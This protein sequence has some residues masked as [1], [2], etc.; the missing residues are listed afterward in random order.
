MEH[1]ESNS[2]LSDV[3]YEFRSGRSCE[4]QLLRVVNYWIDCTDA[5]M[6]CT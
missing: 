3:Q 1:L 5:L 2:L 4:L 6:F